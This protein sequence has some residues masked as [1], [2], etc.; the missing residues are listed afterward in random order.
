MIFQKISNN[1]KSTLLSFLRR[2][3][4]GNNRGR[5]DNKA[6]LILT[7]CF[8]LVMAIFLTWQHSSVSGTLWQVLA[9]LAN[10]RDWATQ[11]TASVSEAMQSNQS[12]VDENNVLRA[13]LLEAQQKVIDRDTLYQENVDLKTRY[14]RPDSVSQHPVLSG[15]IARPPQTPAN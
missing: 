13:Q 3:Y 10:M 14:S 8:V 15:I 12:L 4:H 2:S 6:R 9:P 1:N 5:R 7:A 11:S